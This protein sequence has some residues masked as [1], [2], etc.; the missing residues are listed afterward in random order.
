MPNRMGLKGTFLVVSIRILKT[1]DV[2]FFWK[3]GIVTFENNFV[4][5]TCWC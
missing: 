2:L 5:S 4:H 3:F 1:S